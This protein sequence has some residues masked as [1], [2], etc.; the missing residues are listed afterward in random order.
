M[1]VRAMKQS[2]QLGIIDVIVMMMK[3]EGCLYQSSML[4]AGSINKSVNN[5]GKSLLQLNR[6][7]GIS[8]STIST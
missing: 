5:F 3:E 1:N 4:I 8:K 7:Y 6:E 2:F